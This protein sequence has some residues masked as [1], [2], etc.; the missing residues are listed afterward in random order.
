MARDTEVS[1]NR[2]LVESQQILTCTDLKLQV[3]STEKQSSKES[4]GARGLGDF[5]GPGGQASCLTVPPGLTSEGGGISGWR[6]EGRASQ[7]RAHCTV[8]ARRGSREQDGEEH[9]EAARTHDAA[10]CQALAGL[11]VLGYFVW[12]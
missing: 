4:R 10:R 2:C 1:G 8:G 12:S 7:G 9:S 3:T 6:Q 11:A 5:V